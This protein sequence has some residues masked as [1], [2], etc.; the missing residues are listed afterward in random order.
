MPIRVAVGDV[1]TRN[2]V[3]I[4]S[5]A[6]LH[7]SAKEMVKKRVDSLL[8]SK[9]KKLLGIITSRDIIWAIIKKPGLNLKDIKTIDIATKKVAVIKPSADIGQAIHKMKKVGFKRLPVLTRGELVGIVTL[10]DILKIDPT[11]YSE[12]GELARIREE[13]VKLKKI[14]N[15]DEDVFVEGLCEECGALADLLRVNNKLLCPD[16]RNDLY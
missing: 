16:C 15:S 10:K 4:S 2:F 13:S 8:I 7:Q 1:M 11:L 9:D 5:E 14:S 6:T 3:S 12:L